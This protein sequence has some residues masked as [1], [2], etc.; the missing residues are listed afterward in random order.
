MPPVASSNRPR[1]IPV[2][3]VNEPRSCPNSSLSRIDS[4][5]AAQLTATKGRLVRGDL[6]WMLRATSSLPVPLSPM[7]ST[8]A[9]VA[10][11]CATVLYTPIIAGAVPTMLASMAICARASSTGTFV[12]ASLRRAT[13]SPTIRFSSL[14]S[15]G[16]AR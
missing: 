16:L 5:S 12:S 14:G 9:V 8:V 1:F 10:A 7:I 3:P 4:G 6:A 13:A 2:A 15:T 11:T